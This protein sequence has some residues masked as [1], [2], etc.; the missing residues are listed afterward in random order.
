MRT[1]MPALAFAIAAIG[2]S[3]Q[4]GQFW[5]SSITGTWYAVAN[6]APL[7]VTIASQSTT[8]ICQQITGTILDNTTKVT[9]KLL[10]FYCP[11]SGHYGFSRS[12]SRGFTYQVYSGAVSDNGSTIQMGGTFDEVAARK[13]VGEYAFL[14]DK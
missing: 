7:T 10:G 6:Q 5:P 8:G 4:A 9:D 14:A 11:S 12:N 1:F 3:A 13:A 2:G